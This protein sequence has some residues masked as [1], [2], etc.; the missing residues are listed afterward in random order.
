MTIINSDESLSRFI[1]ELRE[2]Y[3][4]H[5]YLEV[6][7]KAGTK[8]SLNQNAIS[9]VWYEQIAREL[10]E[11]DTL[12]WK[13]YS[14]YTLGVP[15]LYASDE[16]FATFWQNNIR[17]SFTYEQKIEMMKFMPVTS[18]MNKETLSKYLE[19]MIEHFAKRGVMLQFPN[20]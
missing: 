15:L 8:R 10:R 14:K 12:G 19:A 13:C 1:G 16:E 20:E 7:V 5:R 17:M 6:K 2:D 18:I 4:K 3:F 11:Y 9:H